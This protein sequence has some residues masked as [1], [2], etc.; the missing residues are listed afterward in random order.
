M[1]IHPGLRLVRTTTAICILALRGDIVSPQSGTP[2]GRGCAALI[3]EPQLVRC[4]SAKYRSQDI[5]RCVSCA[6]RWQ[7]DTCR[8]RGIRFLC[9]DPAGKLVGFYFQERPQK[10]QLMNWRTVWNVPLEVNH[11][12]TMKKTIAE[13]LLPTLH[14]ELNHI[15][16]NQVVY[17]PRETDVRATC[18]SCLT[19]LF[20]CSWICRSCGREACAECFLRVQVL[21]SEPGSAPNDV[22]EHCAAD[23]LAITRFNPQELTN[24]I[25]EMCAVLSDDGTFPLVSGPSAY[26]EVASGHSPD[27]EMLDIIETA[28]GTSS[29]TA[30]SH[31]IHRY[32]YDD[33][34]EDVFR[35][36]W[37]KGDPI[38]VTDVARR[39]TIAWTPEYFI[40]HYGSDECDVT[41]CQSNTCKRTTVGE[42]FETFGQYQ[43]RQNCWKLKDWPPSSDFKT[44]FPAL[45]DDFNQ[46]VPVPSYARDDGVFNIASHFPFNVIAPDL[47]PKMYNA[48]ANLEDSNTQGSTRL[49]M[50]MADAINIMAYAARDPKGEEGR[51]AWDIFRA[52]DSDKIRLFMDMKYNLPPGEDPIHSQKIYLDDDA[53]LEL[54]TTFKVKSYRVYQTAGQ[55]VFIPAG[56]A[57]QVRNLS[58]CIKVAIDFVSPENIQRCE[59]LTRE[60]R[61]E[62]QVQAWKEDILQLRSMMWFAWLSSC[63]Q[64]RKR[65][66]LD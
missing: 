35:R 58:D 13:A 46:A 54:W 27:V 18:D 61:Q 63:R 31:E 7:H 19:S 65:M 1:K 56:C 37:A 39:L 15:H 36:L 9:R 38:L 64:D 33:L 23:F 45:Y 20:S 28:T 50:D 2:L 25:T 8:F 40:E 49:H 16:Q 24:A 59:K 29:G 62:N 55:A 22:P 60:F 51:A 4:T 12:S 48:H 52:Q 44:T 34:K 43:G 47:G 3:L 30:P 41:E 5:P 6:Q 26:R 53:R 17:R 11:I 66:Q 57:H 32:S 42:F 10:I 21:S 14:A